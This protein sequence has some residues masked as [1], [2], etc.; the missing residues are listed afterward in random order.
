MT[1]EWGAPRVDGSGPRDSASATDGMVAARQRVERALAAVGADMSGLPL[2]LCG[3]LKGLEMIERERGWPPRSAK[4][5]VR[6]ALGRLAEHYGLGREAVGPERSR[7]RLWHAP[8]VPRD[9]CA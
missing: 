7:L 1:A 3:F 5:V 4:V 9:A 8:G 2:D 6:M